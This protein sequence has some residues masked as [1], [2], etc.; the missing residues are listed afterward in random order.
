MTRVLVA[1]DGTDDSV[2]AATIAAGLF[3][4]EAEYLV[5]N[6]ARTALEFPETTTFGGVIPLNPDSWT[7]LADTIDTAASHAAEVGA[8][9]A[10][11][12]SAEV[13]VEHGD[14]VQAICAAAAE[15]AVDVI[16]VGSH[17]KGR[18]ARLVSP[19]VADGVVH[20]TAVPVLV[21]S[22]AAADA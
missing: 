11:L 7:A 21:V 12:E 20:H 22:G 15:H 8:E 6:V 10:G 16:V 17:D 19:S 14:P 3:G 9:A 18:L 13:V 2:R 1:L 4:V 5:V